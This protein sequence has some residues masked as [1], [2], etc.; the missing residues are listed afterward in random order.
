MGHLAFLWICIIHLFCLLVLPDRHHHYSLNRQFGMRGAKMP[1]FANFTNPTLSG[2]NLIDGRS[3]GN[4]RSFIIKRRETLNYRCGLWRYRHCNLFQVWVYRVWQP[5]SIKTDSAS[6]RH[7]VSITM[8]SLRR[9][10]LL[11]AR[12][13]YSAE[14]CIQE[15]S[16]IISGLHLLYEVQHGRAG[17][18]SNKVWYCRKVGCC[19]FPPKV[20]W[21]MLKEFPH[22]SNHGVSVV[23][24]LPIC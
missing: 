3:S 9:Y 18:P 12:E 8:I 6:S 24:L 16:F 22:R 7:E 15:P 19:V 14:C 17:Q 10:I 1:T 4:G 20:A 2:G 11:L 13:A 21:L 5:V 23:A